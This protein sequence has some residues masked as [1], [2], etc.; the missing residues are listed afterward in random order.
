MTVAATRTI[1]NDK[2]VARKIP[3]SALSPQVLSEMEGVCFERIVGPGIAGT[4]ALSRPVSQVLYI[5][6]D[7]NA[8]GFAAG[9]AAPAALPVPPVTDFTLVQQNGNGV[10]TLT[11]ASSGGGRNYSTSRL[12]IWYRALVP[13]DVPGGASTVTP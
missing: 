13:A 5:L 11:E 9:G 6:A 2:D 7:N 10:G 1:N 12:A 3:A 8:G 4:V